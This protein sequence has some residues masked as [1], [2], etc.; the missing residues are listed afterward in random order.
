M[1][2]PRKTL[3]PTGQR[4]M[5]ILG[6]GLPHSRYDLF[7]ALQ[8]PDA[9]LSNIRAHITWIREV[10]RPRGED[11]VCEINPGK[12]RGIFYRHVRLMAS[13]NDGRK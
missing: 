13:A 4:M 5:A 1:A 9:K 12:R 10:I 3:T 7:T 6:D 2:E 8:T 11:I